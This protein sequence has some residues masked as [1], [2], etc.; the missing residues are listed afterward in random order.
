[1][2]TQYRYRF[3]T[4]EIDEARQ[5]L[6]VG[7]VPVEL[8]QRPLQLLLELARH[9][10]EAVT[11][12]ELLRSV[13]DRPTVENVLANAIAKLRRALGP[14]EG[15]RIV[16]LPKVGYRLTGPVE[17]TA[18]G[19]QLSSA[20]A[21]RVGEHL[22]PRPQFVLERQLGASPHHEVWL[23]RHA[24]THEPRVYKFAADGAA[25]SRIKREAT[26]YRLLA[27]SLGDRAALVRMID[28]NFET[29]P[30]FLESEY[31]GPNLAEWAAD[32]DR[33]R[34]LSTAQRLELFVPLVTAIAEAHAIGVLHKDIKP[35]NLLVGESAGVLRLRLVDFGTGQLLEPERLEALG[36]TRLGLTLDASEGVSGTPLYLA[37]E[38]LVGGL[39]TVRSDVYALGLLLYQVL[40]GDLA[41]PLAPGWERDVDDEL[42][43]D[44]IAAATQVDPARRLA[45]ASELEARLLGLDRRRVERA[46][47]HAREQESAAI[48][49]QLER[50]RARRPW[51][52]MALVLLSGL[53]GLSS[54]FYLTSRST[55]RQLALQVRVAETVNRFMIEDLIGESSPAVRGRS[56]VTLL[57]AARAAATRIDARF[58]GEAP[59]VRAALHAAMQAALSDL[60]DARA[61]IDAG[62][63]AL[64][65]LQDSTPADP[66]I[67]ARVRVRLA[68]DL[69]RIGA[70]SRAE[71]LL[72]EVERDLHSLGPSNA[73]LRIEY[74]MARAQLAANRLDV[75]RALEA[76]S[77]AWALL[78][79]LPDASDDLRDRLQFAMGNSL[80]M[81]GNVREG[82]QMSR[83]L[84][85][86]QRKRL[87]PMHQQTLYS[88]VML[89][90]TLLLQQRWDEV[91][92]LLP[93]A[94]RGLDD[95][96]GPDH[97]RS[98]LAHRVLGQAQL[99][100]G[101]ADEAIATF[102][103][104]HATLARK[105]GERHQGTVSTLALVG[106]A[107]F[108]AGRQQDAERSFRTALELARL[109]GDER[110]AS[111]QK[112]RYHLALC[113]LAQDRAAEAAPLAQ[114]LDP[115][116]LAPAE[117]TDDWPSRLALLDA[118]LARARGDESGARALL[119]DAR[120]ALHAPQRW[121]L[122]R[123][124]MQIEE[125]AKPK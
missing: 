123:L 87:G 60:S 50:S 101:H 96:L 117:Q 79:V 49:R 119:A 93:A 89:A 16:T 18:V 59:G 25:L 39:P 61:A 6:A 108:H 97:A 26:L 40:A 82:E 94:I 4:V 37:P 21:L 106:L 32:G 9:A 103:G 75:D 118:R 110:D 83:E 90:H 43:R 55:A 48:A 116:S 53:L 14:V 73:S 104:V 45:S 72:A 122:D 121:R 111:V 22:G 81:A 10:D 27:G 95:A 17:R 57:D 68:Q 47:Q 20:L 7:G 3:G 63:R 23:A 71:T 102:Q 8:E 85:E 77:E 114:G 115:V 41:R 66:V 29:A 31:G 36:I 33:L 84:V 112:F 78:Q 91:Q 42:L 54:W 70:F 98:L 15:E 56:D 120:A 12:E 80:W 19:R 64:L 65:A 62:D 5:R 11:K 38:L 35:T 58:G 124:A 67:A 100:A 107:Q 92:A 46:A 24:R 113:L 51:V 44:D 2:A 76:N 88:T 109:T 1:M 69:A 99:D 125:F 52:A 34:Q 74:L 30:W 28:W 13:W 105:F 86:R